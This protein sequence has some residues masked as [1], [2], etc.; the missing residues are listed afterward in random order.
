MNRD[1]DFHNTCWRFKHGCVSEDEHH[2]CFFCGYPIKVA[3]EDCSVCGIMKCPFCGKC[4]CNITDNKYKTVT[5]IHN[6]FCKHLDI[7]E[8][9]ILPSKEADL[10][11]IKHCERAIQNCYDIE[12]TLG[13]IK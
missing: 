1:Y 9:I 6:C 5:T 11:V 3:T 4:L 12:K 8:G 2:P 10:T 13:N 7:W